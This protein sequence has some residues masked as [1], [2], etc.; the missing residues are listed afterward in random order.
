MLLFLFTERGV[1]LSERAANSMAESLR[2][3]RRSSSFISQNAETGFD[4]LLYGESAV[5]RKGA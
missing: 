1:R 3:L 2:W 5:E 4:V